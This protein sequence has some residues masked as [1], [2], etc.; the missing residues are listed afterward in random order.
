MMDDKRYPEH[1]WPTRANIVRR[2]AC[3]ILSAETF[4]F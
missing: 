4:L 1:L 2:F 3:G